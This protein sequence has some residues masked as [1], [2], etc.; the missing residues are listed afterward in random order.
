MGV[1]VE[2][3]PGRPGVHQSGADRGDEGPVGQVGRPAPRGDRP[4]RG[5]LGHLGGHVDPA[6]PALFLGRAVVDSFPPRLDRRLDLLQRGPVE[7]RV[8]ARVQVAECAQRAGHDDEPAAGSEHGAK[9][10]QDRVGAAVGDV[11]EFVGLLVLRPVRGERGDRVGDHDVHPAVAVSQLGGQ[12]GHG[13][14]IG[15]VE[16]PADHPAPRPGARADRGGG[17]GDPPGVAPGEQ[18]QVAGVH[19]G[20]QARGEGEPQPLVGPGDQGDACS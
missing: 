16:N 2:P 4:D 14:G 8:Q 7:Q 15:D 6:G 20:G 19:A 17:V 9:G 13:A 1:V 3:G 18:D 12:P 5:D 11:D 10:A